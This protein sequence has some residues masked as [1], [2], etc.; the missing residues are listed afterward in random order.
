MAGIDWSEIRAGA[1]EAI[2]EAGAAGTLRRRGTGAGSDP[3]NP[4][5]TSTTD[6]AVTV[7]MT[8]YDE[9][10]RDGTVIQQFDQRA[11]M[12]APVEPDSNTDRLIW[13][14]K[15]YDIINVSALAPG[16]VPILYQC[17]VRR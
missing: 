12:S 17:Q 14:G 13:G 11:L 4:G 16:G 2:A 15:T 1:D 8:D 7:V 6:Y 10:D 5:A 9:R 3:W